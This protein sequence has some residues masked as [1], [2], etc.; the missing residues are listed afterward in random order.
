M[1]CGSI[2]YIHG[3]HDDFWCHGRHFVGEAV[4]VD[5]INSGS[6]GIF[7]I[8][9]SVTCFDDFSVGS[10]NTEVNIKK[11]TFCY[12]KSQTWKF[13]NKRLESDW[14]H[15]TRRIYLILCQPSLFRKN[16]LLRERRQWHNRRRYPKSEWEREWWRL[17]PNWTG[18]PFYWEQFWFGNLIA[19]VNQSGRK[20]SITAGTQSRQ[21]LTWRS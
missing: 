13:G 12:F 11:T 20:K 14:E 8:G 10:N 6:K 2:S 15:C 4:S 17:K 9:D 21:P 5:T 1:C 16:I 7:A 19:E 3:K 18:K